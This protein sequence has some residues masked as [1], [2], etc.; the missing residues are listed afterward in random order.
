MDGETDWKL[1]LT[2]PPCQRLPCDDVSE[3][4]VW[5]E[6]LL[7]RKRHGLYWQYW[8]RVMSGL[9]VDL[10]HGCIKYS[11]IGKSFN[12]PYA[13]LHLEYEQIS[14]TSLV[15]KQISSYLH[16]L[17]MGLLFNSTDLGIHLICQTS[18]LFKMVWN[19][20]ILAWTCIRAIDVAFNPL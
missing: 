1:R 14:P 16:P 10:V 3:I 11:L 8:S 15:C 9:E 19:L 20:L 17:C 13:W 12:G 18:Q 6:V 4:W 5:N 2:V 7:I